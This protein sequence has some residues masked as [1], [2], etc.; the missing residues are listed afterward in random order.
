M[1]IVRE[2]RRASTGV[3]GGFHKVMGSFLVPLMRT[4]VF[5]GLCWS[6]RVYGNYHMGIVRHYVG[7]ITGFV[8]VM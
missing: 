6:R 4:M 8:G 2:L 3:H 7:D 1:G 5:S